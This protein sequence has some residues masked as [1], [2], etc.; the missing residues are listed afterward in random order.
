MAFPIISIIVPVYNT[1]QYLTECLNSITCQSYKE[2]EIVVVDDAS[3][4]G[5]NRIIAKFQ[6]KDNRI[7]YFRH[8]KNGGICKARNTGLEHATGKYIAWCDS[9][10]VLHPQFIEYL[11]QILTREDADFVECQSVSDYIFN[12]NFTPIWFGE[13][14][15]TGDTTDFLR[16]FATHEL[17]TSLWSK[18]FRREL[19]NGFSFPE[20]RIYEEFYFYA[21]VHNRINKASYSPLPLYFYRKRANSIMNT[22]RP[23]ELKECLQVINLFLTFPNNESEE[24]KALFRQKALKSLNLYWQRVAMMD[25]SLSKKIRY[26]KLVVRFMNK[27]G[28]T[29]NDIVS[30][31]PK[32]Q[33]IY[34][35]RNNILLFFA[36][37][38]FRKYVKEILNNKWKISLNSK[39]KG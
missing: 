27:T 16:R 26:H 24:I 35:H 34:K 33:L 19:F 14:V 23:K 18:L 6:Q 8:K 10:D 7:K 15:I 30:L 3:T 2:L 1:E 11:H 9:D 38:I 12:E 28:A 20:G 37:T 39:T 36:Y 4:D 32:Q 21:A 13:P 22:F 25:V 29:F 17:Q 31:S 5:S